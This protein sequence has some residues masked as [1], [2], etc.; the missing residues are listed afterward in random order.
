MFKFQPRVVPSNFFSVWIIH[1][2]FTPTSQPLISEALNTL[3]FKFL[4]SGWIKNC[5]QESP[6]NT[7]WG[8]FPT[9]PTNIRHI[10][11]WACSSD[12]QAWTN[13]LH[14]KNFQALYQNTWEIFCSLKHFMNFRKDHCSG[15]FLTIIHTIYELFQLSK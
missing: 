4:Q 5:T 12:S 15:Y 13:S 7:D 11:F 2:P 1:S 8:Y 14:K 9:I 3:I 6:V 10:F